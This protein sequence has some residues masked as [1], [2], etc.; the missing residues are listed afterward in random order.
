MW[1][2]GLQVSVS[3]WGYLDNFLNIMGSVLLIPRSM[4][5]YWREGKTR[6]LQRRAWSRTCHHVTSVGNSLNQGLLS[7]PAVK[8]CGLNDLQAVL[9]GHCGYNRTMVQ[10]EWDRKSFSFKVSARNCLWSFSLIQLIFF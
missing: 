5:A 3:G 10:E 7:A 6:C 9:L 2:G 4:G 8:S 1:G